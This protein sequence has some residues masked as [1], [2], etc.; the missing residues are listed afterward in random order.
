MQTREQKLKEIEF[1]SKMLGNLK[2]WIRNLIVL[3]SIGAVLAYWGIG[4]MNGMPYRAIGI[5]A[6]IF[7]SICLV[8]C[9]V[10]GLAFKN[11]KE[12]VE[13]IIQLV[14]Q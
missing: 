11:G 9:V 12:N 7:T 14:Q 3:S 13:K 1:Q 6:I 2:K 4:M 8:L 10:V 5:A